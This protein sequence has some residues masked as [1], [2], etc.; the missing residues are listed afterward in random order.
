MKS[1][2]YIDKEIEIKDEF[3]NILCNFHEKQK[4]KDVIR[5]LDDYLEILSLNFDKE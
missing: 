1:P 4:N 2:Y 3:G 5:N